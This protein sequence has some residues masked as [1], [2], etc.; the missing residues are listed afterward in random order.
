MNAAEEDREMALWIAERQLHGLERQ[1]RQQLARARVLFRPKR[2]ARPSRRRRHLSLI[3]VGERLL[4]A[5]LLAG[6]VLLVVVS[7]AAGRR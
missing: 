7:I 1:R 3:Q 6:P 4:Y 2:R 5:L